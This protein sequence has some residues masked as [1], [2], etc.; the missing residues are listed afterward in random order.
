MVSFLDLKKINDQHL[1]EINGAIKR[2]LDSGYYLLGKEN[3][4]FTQNFA[5]YIG[6]DHCVGV[7][8]GLDALT[9]MLKAYNFE[10]GSEII[11]PANTYI[12]SILA[13]SAANLVPILVEPD[14]NTYNIDIRKI[15]SAITAKTKA[16]LVVH[17]YGRA[18]DM[19]DVNK[20]AKKYNLKVFEDCAQAHG[21]LSD[22]KKV[23]SVSDCAAFSFYPG[24]NLGALGDAGAITTND[25]DIAHKIK[26]LANYG[27]DVKYHNIYKGTNSRLDEIQAAVLDVKL[28]YL[29]NENLRR[30]NI[31]HYYIDN[32]KANIK[33]PLKTH[34]NNC[35]WHLFP[36]MVANRDKFMS[37]LKDNDVHT[38]IHYPIPPH[39][40]RAY[41]ELSN[42]SLPITEKIHE[43]IVSLPI[44]P[45]LTDSEVDYVIDIVNKYKG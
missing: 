37:Y 3:S 7:G 41:Y 18:V 25:K 2:V 16:I 33:L 26:V 17:L 44:S 23:G 22:G 19:T 43:Q 39:K 27:S 8:N 5:Q 12:A 1:D 15:E 36:I 34:N 35:V 21:A 9:L 42:L 24:K 30:L 11:V 45:V 13:I 32:I 31:A 4:N 10:E 29:D 40:Q 6:V 20:I 28:K 38:L 14:I